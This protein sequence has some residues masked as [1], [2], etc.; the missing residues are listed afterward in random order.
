MDYPPLLFHPAFDE[1]LT[2]PDSRQPHSTTPRTLPP[3]IALDTAFGHAPLVQGNDLKRRYEQKNN[4]DIWKKHRIGLS[5]RALSVR[6]AISPSMGYQSP[7]FFPPQLITPEGFQDSFHQ[8]RSQFPS[9]ESL[10]QLQPS[11]RSANSRANKMP[12]EP[13]I[14]I[15]HSDNGKR[16]W[17]II[18]SIGKG[19]CGEVYLA[20]E[21]M[22]E[23]VVAIK[24]VKVTALK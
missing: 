7:S 6:T 10:L 16:R 17:D 2:P 13:A 3:M 15:L 12:P 11:P 9:R 24:I 14:R 1:P 20:K 22:S 4:E 8:F 21:T 18:K 23:N 19:G 5:Q